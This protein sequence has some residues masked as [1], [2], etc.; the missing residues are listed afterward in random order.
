MLSDPRGYLIAC[1]DRYL[2]SC[3]GYERLLILI[4]P[5]QLPVRILRLLTSGRNSIW[6]K[7][8]STR[9]ISDFYGNIR[10]NQLAKLPEFEWLFK[11]IIS[12]ILINF[13]LFKDLL[14]I[15]HVKNKIPIIILILNL[16]FVYHSI[17]NLYTRIRTQLLTSYY[18]L[19]IQAT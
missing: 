2:G 19:V 10:N 11:R 12:F 14:E 17:S 7:Q 16:L 1:T 15:K 5:L 3:G 8:G 18:L 9:W 13:F 6:L 4:L